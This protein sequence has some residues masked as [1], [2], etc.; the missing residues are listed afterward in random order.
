M[1]LD[2][3]K[4]TVHDG[5]AE[6]V[7][8]RPPVNAI[9]Q[10]MYDEINRVFAHI[11]DF[12]DVVV[13]ILRGE[14][15][16]F[17]GGNDLDEFATL[18]PENSPERMWHVREA[19]WAVYDCAVPVVSAVRG[20]AI[21]SGLCLAASA[22]V[23]VASET[24]RFGLP[25]ITVGVMGGARHAARLA[26][27]MVVR[28]LFFSG[29]PV[30]VAQLEPYGAITA[31]VAD[32]ELEDEARRRAAAIARH[33]PIALRYAKK[34]LNETEYMDLK[35]GYEREQSFTHVMSG[36]ADSKEAVAAFF[37]KRPPVYKGR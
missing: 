14:G 34:A 22:D 29:E 5:I 35:L 32:D 4:V 26:P 20:V 6:V 36:T 17:C 24:A 10:P 8:N 2:Y 23:I 19:F 31:I 18:T 9:N 28:R 27:H 7:L 12:G 33:S 30:P 3:V 15:K 1:D 21:G 25:E 16:H 11:D 37:E 13:A